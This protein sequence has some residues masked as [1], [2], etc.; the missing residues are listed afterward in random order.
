MKYL[1]IFL[2]VLAIF[3][4]SV[5]LGAHNDQVVAFNYLI[6]QGEYRLSTL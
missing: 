4:L 3:V 2:I 6:A 5:T 1:L